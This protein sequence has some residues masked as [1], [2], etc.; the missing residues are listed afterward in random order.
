MNV[1]HRILLR[2]GSVSPFS[3]L[4]IIKGQLKNPRKKNPFFEGIATT[5]IDNFLDSRVCKSSNRSWE[6]IV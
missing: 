2:E 6:S 3:T 5:K 1:L 4:D